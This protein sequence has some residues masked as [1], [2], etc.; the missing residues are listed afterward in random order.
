VEQP[1]LKHCQTHIHIYLQPEWQNQS[2]LELELGDDYA[3]HC[4]THILPRIM[5]YMTNPLLHFTTNS[6]KFKGNK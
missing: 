2:E 1:G 3:G 6:M 5:L 4:Q